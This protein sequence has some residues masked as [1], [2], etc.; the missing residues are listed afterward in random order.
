MRI[1]CVNMQKNEDH[2]LEP[3]VKYHGYLFGFEN[4]FLIDHASTSKATCDYLR[5]IK[6]ASV[7]IKYLGKDANYQNKGEFVAA[8][9]RRIDEMAH[10]DFVFPIDCDEFLFLRDEDGTPVCSRSKIIKYLEQFRE[11]AGR[12][13]IKENFL[14]ILGK[15]GYF[16]SQPYQKVFFAG[17]QCESLDHGSHMGVARGGDRSIVTRLAY[18]HFHFKPYEIDRELSREK[19]RPWVDV[20]D[21]AAVRAFEGPGAHLRNHLLASREEYYSG[22]KVDANAIYFDDMMRLFSL[23]DIDP[24]FSAI[25]ADGHVFSE[26]VAS[27]RPTS[28]AAA[29]DESGG[30]RFEPL[31]PPA[32]PLLRPSSA[33]QSSLSDW[34]F[35]RSAENDALGALDGLADGVF[36][37]HTAMEDCPWWMVDLGAVHGIGEIR[38]FNRLD[39]PGIAARTARL[40]IDAGMAEDKMMEVYR[41]ETDVSFGGADG[42]PLVFCPSIPIPGRFV[43]VRLLTRNYLHLDQVEIYGELLSGLIV[44]DT[45]QRDIPAGASI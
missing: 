36:G 17:G 39:D 30:M 28:V 1:A 15:S 19:L 33:W 2:C 10:F 6:A 29:A 13:E 24:N 4:L 43:R 16:W 26:Q 22:F 14:H 21:P 5:K 11:F 34:S 41:R 7:S 20:D 3:W 31:K 8:E 37:M 32:M 45:L 38:I 18:A 27:D 40:A 9:I 25:D 35:R 12:L 42:N 23:L 44:N